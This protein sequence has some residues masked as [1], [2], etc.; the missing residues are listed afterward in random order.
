MGEVDFD[1]PLQPDPDPD[2]AGFWA[3]TQ[4]GVLR[5]ARCEVCSRWS[6]P[7]VERCRACD[8]LLRFEKILGT[9]T[10]F[11]LIQV[12][13]PSVPGFLRDLPYRVGLVELD[14]QAGLRVVG[15][16]APVWSAEPAIGQRVAVRLVEL[17]GGPY[18][19]PEFHPIES[20][21]QMEDLAS[22][23]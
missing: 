23:P 9:G 15:G 13:Q 22:E 6:H 19:T 17:P 8:G 2:T 11:S 3:A 7:P 18:R 14:D 12:H 5:M 21:E 20:P 4:A 10:V 1:A 16:F